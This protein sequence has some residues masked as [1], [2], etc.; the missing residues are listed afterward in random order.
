MIEIVFP[1]Q[2]IC[3][4]LIACRI[5]IEMGREERERTCINQMSIL[6][7]DLKEK[8][9]QEMIKL[10]LLQD[11]NI[12]AAVSPFLKKLD[13]RNASGI[14]DQGLYEVACEQKL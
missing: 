5:T 11:Y 13:L 1:L 2:K 10:H 4:R 9:L 3:L 14:T 12:R 7:V 6:P 8:L